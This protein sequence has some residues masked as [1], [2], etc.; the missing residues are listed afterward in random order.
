MVMPSGQPDATPMSAP[1][2]D[3][4]RRSLRRFVE[5]ELMPFERCAMS[6]AEREAIQRKAKDAGFWLLDVPESLGGQG[7]GLLG[8]SVFWHEISSTTAVP[9]RDLNI[10]ATNMPSACRIANIDP[11]DAMIL[12][13]DANRRRIIFSERTGVGIRHDN[14]AVGDCLRLTRLKKNVHVSIAYRRRSPA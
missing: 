4:F 5:R 7:L 11:N 13:H 14:D 8:M 1:E 10:S 3:E 9:A 6:N 12:P 2:L